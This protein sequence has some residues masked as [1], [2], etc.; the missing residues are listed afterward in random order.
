[1]SK[2]GKQRRTERGVVG[3]QMAKYGMILM[4]LPKK[5]ILMAYISSYG[6]YPNSRHYQKR[7]ELNMGLAITFQKRK[8]DGLYKQWLDPQLPKKEI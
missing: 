3:V 2:R 1:M 4:G 5:E 6:R 7:K 8:F